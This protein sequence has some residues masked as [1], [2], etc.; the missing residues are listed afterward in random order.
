VLP[1]R[2][3]SGCSVGKVAL[4]SHVRNF[5]S[6]DKGNVRLPNPND[7]EKGSHPHCQN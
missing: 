6:F 3:I 1:Q 2:G 4:E 5:S 7:Y